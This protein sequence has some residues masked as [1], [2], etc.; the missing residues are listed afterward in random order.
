[1]EF[2]DLQLT[3]TVVV[4]SAA[5]LIVLFDYRRKQRRQPQPQRIKNRNAGRPERSVLSFEP[6]ALEYL[7][8]R[9][10]AAER[11]LEPLL[12]TVTIAK[13]PASQPVER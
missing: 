12:A 2:T 3:L 8:A 11:P 6:A 5:A 4:L 9:K 13:P 10:L 7:P 1:M